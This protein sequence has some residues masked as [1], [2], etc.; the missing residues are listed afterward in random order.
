MEHVVLLRGINVGGKNKI[1]M[2]ALRALLAEEFDAVRTYIQSGNVVLACDL[3]ACEVAARI[4]SLLPTAFA[5]SG[6]VRVLAL[7]AS[8]YRR[9]VA[10]AP[11]GFGDDPEAYRYDVGFY[12]GVT[13]PE[14]AP[15][16]PVHPDVDVVTFGEHAYYHRRL[17]ALATR[18]RV[19]K[20]VGSPVY[21][22]L[23]VRN[24]RTTLT[25]A[26]MLNADQA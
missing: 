15:H 9:V 11:A 1:P 12:V 25:L 16:V 17:N 24:W 20:V 26:Q 19:T 23:T 5:L 18:S 7:E 3:A 14:V 21:P 22:S 2:A 10:Q 6:P 8:T 4:E 13:A